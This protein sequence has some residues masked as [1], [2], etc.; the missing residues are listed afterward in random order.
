MGELFATFGVNWKLLL[1]QAVNFGLLLSVLTYFLYKPILRI[2][3]ERREKI[4][5]GVRTAEAAAKQ[6]ADAKEER[7][8][9]VGTAAREAEGLVASART[10]A[11]ERGTEIV[12]AAE[13]R[14][15]ATIK[16]AAERAEEAK[17][18]ALKESEREIARA[19]MLAAEKILA[20]K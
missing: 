6:L 12:K 11:D 19:A 3:D 14:A 7:E 20:S 4:A 15:A 16:D 2:I 13:A 18:Q 9:I 10:R 5:E 17:R 1:I 8:G